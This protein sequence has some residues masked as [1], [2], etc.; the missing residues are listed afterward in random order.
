MNKLAAY[1]KEGFS[2]VEGWVQPGALSALEALNTCIP[3]EDNECG[4]C[5]IGVHH[6]KFF[7]AMLACAGS[8]ASLAIDIFEDQNLNLDRSGS[9]SIAQFENNIAQF[10]PTYSNVSTMRADSLGITMSQVVQVRNKFDGFKMFSVDGGHTR[11]HALN[12]ILL[13]QELI[14][15]GGIVA[16]DDFFHPEWPGVT[17]GV[18]QY[19]RS[20]NAKLAPICLAG[21]KLFLCLLSNHEKYVDISSA[22][23]RETRP[24]SV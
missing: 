24:Q 23:L 2:K 11:T 9:G 16:V 1:Y 21:S 14:S 22:I 19:Y 13:A 3:A 17:E 12:D 10:S 7:L 6:G 4:V 15:N 20:S 5:E 18:Y 8:K